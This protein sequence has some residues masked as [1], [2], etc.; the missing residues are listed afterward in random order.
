MKI[1]LQY[2]EY[3]INVTTNPIS[4]DVIQEFRNCNT[5]HCISCFTPI[6]SSSTSC[7]SFHQQCHLHHWHRIDEKNLDH[8]VWKRAKEQAVEQA[9]LQSPKI[10]RKKQAHISKMFWPRRYVLV[11]R[12]P[13][14]HGNDQKMEDIL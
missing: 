4:K 14:A 5:S 12:T 6:A 8:F 9:T 13:L 3:G 10:V 11:H 1:P 7:L 2:P